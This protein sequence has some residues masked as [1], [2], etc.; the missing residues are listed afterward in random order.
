[1]CRYGCCY[2]T[3]DYCLLTS[4][5]FFDMMD[6]QPRVGDTMNITHEILSAIAINKHSCGEDM[7]DSRIIKDLLMDI[8][9]EN[10]LS[11]EF[12]R[13]KVFG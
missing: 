13:S 3:S 2:Y 5:R 11:F 9:L 4:P 1:M 8:D 12:D 6:R 7:I 10:V